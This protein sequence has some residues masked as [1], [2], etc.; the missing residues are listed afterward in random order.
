MRRV[1]DVVGRMRL[2]KPLFLRSARGP[3]RLEAVVALLLGLLVLASV[4]VICGRVVADYDQ[5]TATAAADGRSRHQV[6]ATVRPDLPVPSAAAPAGGGLISVTVTWVAPGGRV[7]SGV[8]RLGA[9][10]ALPPQVWLWV[11]GTGAQVAPPLS[12]SEAFTTA[13]LG[14]LVWESVVLV[15][16]GGAYLVT[17]R[18]LD[19][20][21]ARLRERDWLG[22]RGGATTP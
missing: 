20:H 14:G 5:L 11:D 16:L 8:V 12:G 6:A 17:R 15:V 7:R 22:R 9:G 18:A 2:F 21:R 3:D 19:R 1:D 13:I 10:S 4:A